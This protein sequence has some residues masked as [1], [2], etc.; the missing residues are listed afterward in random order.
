[1]Q[2]IPGI[3][4]RGKVD[5]FELSKLLKNVKKKYNKKLG[6]I[7]NSKKESFFID[8]D[9]EP[10]VYGDD[11]CEH[12]WLQIPLISFNDSQKKALKNDKLKNISS[13]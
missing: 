9:R 11:R 1:M 3:G 5:T 7:L 4:G 10:I 6:V 8:M 12:M 2:K 13:T